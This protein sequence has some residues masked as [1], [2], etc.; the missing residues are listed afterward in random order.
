MVRQAPL[1]AS[2]GL[3]S[4]FRDVEMPV[5]GVLGEMERVGIGLDVPRLGEIAARVRDNADELRDRIWELAGG[6]F[7]IESPKQLG[8]V[9]FGDSACRPSG[10]ARPAGPPT[11]RC[12]AASRDKHEIVPLIGRYRELTKLDNTYLTALPELVD[13]RDGRLHTTFKQTV[14]ETGRLSSTNPNLQNIPVRTA[15]GREIR[16]AFVP[17]RGWRLVSLDYS[18]VEL[19]I[20]AHVSG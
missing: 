16:D 7:V 18:Q 20:L 6:E 19:R 15:I 11:G 2:E 12:C 1:I 4:L 14:A 10:A 17:V 5:A 9:L 8:E 3:E 13:P